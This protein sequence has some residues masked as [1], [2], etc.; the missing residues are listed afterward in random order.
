MKTYLTLVK[1]SNYQKLH[2][3]ILGG[4]QKWHKLVA[5]SRPTEEFR[6]TTA[7]KI[8]HDDWRPWQSLADC[9]Q[10]CRSTAD[11]VG[12]NLK[13]GEDKGKCEMV[14]EGWPES[15]Q[16]ATGTEEHST[17]SREYCESILK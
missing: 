1:Y 14:K 4:T 13:P 5:G 16:I 12:A 2:L 3:N 7:D 10:K 9:F 15:D 11:C 8:Q 17:M 6:L